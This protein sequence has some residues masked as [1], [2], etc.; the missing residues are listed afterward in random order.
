M[1]DQR[2]FSSFIVIAILAL[3]GIGFYAGA[4]SQKSIVSNVTELFQSPKPS[5]YPTVESTPTSIPK[6]TPKPSSTTS[7]TNPTP[8]PTSSPL[9]T[10]TPTP[11][12]SSSNTSD[13]NAPTFIK[14]S[15]PNGGESFKVR[16]TMHITWSSNNLNK[17]GSCVVTLAYDN[18]SKSSAWV[19]VNTP[20]GYFDWKLTSESGGKQAK[21]DMQCYDSGSNGYND[22]SDNYFTVVN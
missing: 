7:V 4:T 8:K 18:G 15:S 20:N 22:Q 10:A 2:G 14:I 3:L 16:D 19:P 1:L 17:N 11:A 13:S 6:V 9:P 21:I 12:Q 5:V